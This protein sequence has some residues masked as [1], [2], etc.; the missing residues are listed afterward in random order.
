M[1]VVQGI[2]GSRCYGNTQQDNRIAASL[3]PKVTGIIKNVVDRSEIYPNG[4]GLEF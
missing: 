1:G 4:G 2:S 3:L